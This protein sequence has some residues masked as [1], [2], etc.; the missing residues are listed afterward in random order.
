[1]SARELNL[2]VV[3]SRSKWNVFF[4]SSKQLFSAIKMAV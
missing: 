1:M 3:D 2:I 4:V